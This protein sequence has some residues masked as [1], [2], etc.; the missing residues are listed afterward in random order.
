MM[1]RHPKAGGACHG[2]GPPMSGN[3][4][5]WT[6]AA[7][8]RRAPSRWLDPGPVDIISRMERETSLLTVAHRCD[9]ADMVIAVSGKLCD[10]VKWLYNC[11]HKLRMAY[12]AIHL[13]QV[14]PARFATRK[15]SGKMTEPNANGFPSRV[16]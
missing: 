9:Y 2:A 14:R 10:E 12:N 8:G 3:L 1:P 15:T 5:A 11:G 16:F 7:F 6:I 13:S 4:G